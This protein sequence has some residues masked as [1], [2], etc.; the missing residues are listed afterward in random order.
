M[1]TRLASL[2]GA[3]GLAIALHSPA[4]LAGLLVSGTTATGLAG[5]TV[6]PAF[7]VFNDGNSVPEVALDQIAAWDFKLTWDPAAL[8]LDTAASIIS[9]GSFS[10]SLTSLE[11]ILGM[12]AT[13]NNSAGVYALSWMD[14]NA[15]NVLDMTGGIS[16]SGAFNILAGATPGTYGITFSQ[17]SS[18]SSLLDA[19]FAQFDYSDV[20][21]G[22][23]P[24]QVV[25]RQ[26]P[27][28]VQV[29]EPGTLAMLMAGLG[30]FA[31]TR[32]RRQ[33]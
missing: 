18:P 28:P 19:N 26:S 1:S 7:H 21:A 27:P 9:F 10:G 2:I 11:G 6:S 16:F 5:Q 30:A 12:L 23:G 20:S 3:I 32:R 29:P 4:A 15:F 17:S 25:V 24:M 8:S 33:G 13:V 14:P 22:A 31:A